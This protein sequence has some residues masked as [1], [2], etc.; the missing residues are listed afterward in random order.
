MPEFGK[1]RRVD[2]DK[3]QIGMK[4]KEDVLGYKNKVLVSSGEVITRLHVEKMN[5][6]EA[7]EKPQGPVIARRNPKDQNE[8]IRRAE[9][10]GGWR[11]SHFN[12][13]GVLVKAST[14]SGDEYP[15]VEQHPEKSKVF[16]KTVAKTSIA[17]N[18]GP[19]SV[20]VEKRNLRDDIKALIEENH[21]LG[22]TLED[23]TAVLITKESLES[24][25][26]EV[27]AVN[28]RLLA[29]S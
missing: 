14:D 5:K 7:R 4:V 25:R 6:W 3:L 29:D 11:P 21:K 1:T 26:S 2:V 27:E 16:Q 17:I 22:G 15:D 23:K 18:S 28:N 19:E 9:F 8:L 20:L 12:P 24:F 13:K 10:Q